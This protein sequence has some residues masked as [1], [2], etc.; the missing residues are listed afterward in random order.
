MSGAIKTQG[1][2][3]GIQSVTGA[4]SVEFDATAGTIER[5][6]GDWTTDYA[7]GMIVTTSDTDNPGPYII[8]ALTST[9]MTVAGQSKGHAGTSDFVGTADAVMTTDATPASFT[10][11]GYKPIGEVV[12]FDGPGGSASV[13]DA[14]SLDS[15]AKEKIMGL[16]DEGQL[17]FN[18][19]FV[20]GN[21]GQVAYRT[22][23]RTQAKTNF[24][25]VLSDATDTKAATT[26]AFAGFALEFPISGA[27]DDKVSASAVIEITGE[28]DWSD[29]AA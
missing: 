26:A 17:S 16:P 28:V 21:P 20:P 25:L 7:V 14:T 24:L 11:T 4:V 1:T 13:G 2:K 9:V 5:A 23:R 19:I 10:I 29:E 27:V 18:L 15:V 22:A 6:T 12:D 3:L 8:T